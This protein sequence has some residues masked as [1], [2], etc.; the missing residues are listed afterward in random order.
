MQR[1]FAWDGRGRDGKR[2]S[3]EM[4][5][6]SELEVRAKL[7]RAGVTVQGIRVIGEGSEKTFVSP[8]LRDEQLANSWRGRLAKKILNWIDA[9]K[10]RR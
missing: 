1:K 8:A 9:N 5:A 10:K 6:M 2:M 4:D 7:E 3:G